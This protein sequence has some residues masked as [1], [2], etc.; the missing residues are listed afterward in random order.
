MQ[1]NEPAVLKAIQDLLSAIGVNEHEEPY[2]GTPQRVLGV[3]QE[4]FGDDT[5]A[6][7]KSFP[8]QY[9]GIISVRGHEC[10]TLCPHHLLPVRLI[11]DL[12]YKPKPTAPLNKASKDVQVLG[13]SKPAR[14]VNHIIKDKGPALQERVTEDILE[15]LKPHCDMVHVK[16][17]GEHLCIK[18]RGVK[19]SSIME[20]EVQWTN[21]E[22]TRPQ[23]SNIA[24]PRIV[25]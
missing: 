16:V 6:D 23:T 14:L 12:T 18:M 8:E 5:K 9:S 4:C 11:V 10:W 24:K 2:K 20:T 19:S 3:L 25:R 1:L 22:L 17:A 13:L 21:P 7:A 15:T